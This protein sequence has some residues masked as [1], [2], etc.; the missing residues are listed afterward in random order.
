VSTEPTRTR[1]VIVGGGHLGRHAV[2]QL[3]EEQY[4][5]TTV[6]RD[7]P[8]CDQLGS[9]LEEVIEGDGTDPDVFA[10]ATRPEPT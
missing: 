6:E 4:P 8:K 3:G 1:V 2:E 10:R 9:R 5:V 7:S